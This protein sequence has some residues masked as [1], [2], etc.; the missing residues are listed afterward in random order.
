MIKKES[1]MCPR[2]VRIHLSIPQDDARIT[3]PYKARS[4]NTTKHRKRKPVNNR[5]S[6]ED[7][8]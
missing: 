4:A 3:K 8:R 2:G 7:K 1:P 6:D 5:N